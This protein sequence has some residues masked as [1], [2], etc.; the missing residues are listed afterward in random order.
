M[1]ASKSPSKT[2]GG[3]NPRAAPPLYRAAMGYPPTRNH[4]SMPKRPRKKKPAGRLA[5]DIVDEAM[6]SLLEETGRK[7][8]GPVAPGKLGCE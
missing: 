6:G 8:P 4:E 3:R 5:A 2:S 7:N 1:S